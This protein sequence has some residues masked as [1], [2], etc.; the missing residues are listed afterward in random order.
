[1][2][3]EYNILQDA[4]LKVNTLIKYPGI[5]ENPTY[6]EPC[7][8]KKLQYIENKQ[9]VAFWHMLDLETT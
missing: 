8:K 6:K 9:S 3:S 7:R 4:R 1:M 2:Q 5:A